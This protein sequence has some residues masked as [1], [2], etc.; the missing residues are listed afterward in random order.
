MRR[1]NLNARDVERESDFEAA[2]IGYFVADRKRYIDERFFT[3]DFGRKPDD[4][5]RLTRASRKDEPWID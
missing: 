1:A 2:V 5:C 3:T 4:V